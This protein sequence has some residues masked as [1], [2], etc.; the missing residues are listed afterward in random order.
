MQL[1]ISHLIAFALGITATVLKDV[2]QIWVF[3]STLKRLGIE[4][5]GS[6]MDKMM[7]TSKRISESFG[8]N[9]PV[10]EEKDT[11]N[12]EPYYRGYYS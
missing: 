7:A 10:D 2:L 5:Q 3:R 4:D 6:E 9:D 11:E 1:D 12:K 8:L